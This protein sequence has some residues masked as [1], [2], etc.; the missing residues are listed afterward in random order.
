MATPRVLHG[1]PNARTSIRPCLTS[2]GLAVLAM[3]AGCDRPPAV[4]A[5]SGTVTEAPVASAT[6]NPAGGPAVG[7]NPADEIWSGKSIG[8]WIAQLKS[9]DD[10]AQGEATLTLAHIGPPAAAAIPAL[11]EAIKSGPLNVKL[12][13][14]Q[15]LASIDA[16]ELPVF[17][18]LLT[19]TSDEGFVR[20]LAIQALAAYLRPENRRMADGGRPNIRSIDDPYI[21]PKAAAAARLLAARLTDDVVDVRLA[22]ANTLGQLGHEAAGAV[23]AMTEALKDADGKVRAAVL[24]AL[25]RVGPAAAAA[26][27]PSVIS[28]DD[29]LRFSATALITNS[30]SKNSALVAAM[31]ADKDEA[32]RVWA[33]RWLNENGEIIR[34]A[35]RDQ[36]VLDRRGVQ[37]MVEALKDK[38]EDVRWNVAEALGKIGTKESPKVPIVAALTEAQSDSGEKVRQAAGEALKKLNMP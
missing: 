26:V 6:S 30:A 15:A 11:Q 7:K 28:K 3:L 21:D 14:L 33:A 36:G 1:R 18:K 32:V 2:V 29:L 4:P 16:T 24:S 8:Q 22:A 35:Q 31:L 12:G 25:I 5:G 17:G 37:A 10:R 9:E 27:A 20:K 23:P 13:A 38:N 34:N 19:D